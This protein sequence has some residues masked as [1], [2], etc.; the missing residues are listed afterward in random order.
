MKP[1]ACANLEVALALIKTLEA[2]VRHANVK[3]A[4]TVDKDGSIRNDLRLRAASLESLL[5][6]EKD[7]IVHLGKHRVDKIA[8][9][10][11]VLADRSKVHYAIRRL[12]KENCVALRE[13]CVELT[14]AV[15][16]LDT[17]RR[18][19]KILKG[20]LSVT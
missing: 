1:L 13:T 4:K 17:L 12:L 9:N 14:V 11:G 10:K 16:K 20:N 3:Y 5:K 19:Q 15:S 2:L 6:V 18:I 8:E 7:R